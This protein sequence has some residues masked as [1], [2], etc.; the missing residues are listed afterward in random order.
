MKYNI[1]IKSEKGF[2]LFTALVSLMLISMSLVLVFNMVATEETN[3]NLIESKSSNSDLS[4]IADLSKADAFNLF[5]L[6][7]RTKWEEVKSSSDNYTTLTRKE[8]YMPWDEFV[9]SM[10]YS[11]FFGRNVTGY[12][13]ESILN[14][15]EF[16]KSPIGYRVFVNTVQNES[17]FNKIVAQMFLD[18]GEKLD[19]V[20]CEIDSDECTGSFYIT[21]TGENLSDENFEKLPKVTVKRLKNNEVIQK[22]VL[23]RRTYK[24]YIPWRGFQA[25]RTVRRIAMDPEI[26]KLE[27]NLEL[28]QKDSSGLINPTLHNTLEQARLGVCDP[29]T[30]APRTSFFKT[31]EKNGFLQKCNNPVNPFQI[32]NTNINVS[33]TDV[34]L[35]DSISKSYSLSGGI[36]VNNN[37]QQ[38]NNIGPLFKNL[39]ETTFKNNISSRS[40]EISKIIFDENLKLVGDI[41]PDT[42]AGYTSSI[43]LKNI[44]TPISST[45]TKDVLILNDVGSGNVGNSFSSVDIFNPNREFN[46]TWGFGLFN[47]S[48]DIFIPSDSNLPDLSGII[49]LDT[50]NVYMKCYELEKITYEFEFIENNNKY[51]VD[52]DADISMHIRL[53]DN[54]TSFS[55][56]TDYM[57]N[58]LETSLDQYGYIIPK[59]YPI[60]DYSNWYNYVSDWQCRSYEYV[61]TN[62]DDGMCEAVEPI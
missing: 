5:V 3:L 34:K 21:L 29:G 22:P 7:F 39:V 24:I 10:G 60:S 36:N 53:E 19:V 33:G 42:T 26:E 48:N 52:K 15:L 23:D 25:M 55:F 59:S 28:S 44:F 30:C 20:N 8:I 16:T 57:K 46:L 40:T 32:E 11:V 31:P 37:Q 27:S 14:K 47:Y 51:K 49:K 12:F 41:V 1:F 17:E 9:N 35:D 4:T 2:N 45:V 18:A 38:T 43:K 13:S 54:F 56:N 62:T 50:N 61:Q 6:G 58:N